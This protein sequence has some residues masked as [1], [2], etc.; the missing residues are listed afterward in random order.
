MYHGVGRTDLPGSHTMD[1][2]ATPLARHQ[3]WSLF[4]WK[5]EGKGGVHDGSPPFSTWKT[6]SPPPVA[7]RK[8][9]LRFHCGQVSLVDDV[10]SELSQFQFPYCAFPE[11]QRKGETVAQGD[12]MK[13]ATIF[14]STSF[15]YSKRSGCKKGR[16]GYINTGCLRIGSVF[17][18]EW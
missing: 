4:K 3:S 10:F 6:P 16:R 5:R 9:S 14:T 18:N 7:E 8:E 17:G 2:G 15:N 13:V 12:G 11:I 1:V